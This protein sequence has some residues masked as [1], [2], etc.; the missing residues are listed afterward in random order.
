M[1]SINLYKKINIQSCCLVNLMIKNRNHSN[2]NEQSIGKMPNFMPLKKMNAETKQIF[3]QEKFKFLED[4]KC[5]YRFNHIKT[6]TTLSR[7]KI[8]Q[9]GFT[10]FLGLATSVFYF[11]SSNISLKAFLIINGASLAAL[12]TLFMFSKLFIN[13][14]CAIYLHKNGEN[15]I[16][17]HINFLA[18]RKNIETTVSNIKP[19]INTMD[20]LNNMYLKFNL[21]DSEGTMYY[22]LI[23]GKIFDKNDLF[24]VLKIS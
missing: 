8:Y 5:I 6:L 24:K 15:V 14:I 21:L 16:I 13:I 22:S 1:L 19:L 10:C 20:D 4:Y 17:S 18:R 3:V 11:V 23:H 9:S 12:I 7:L 2:K